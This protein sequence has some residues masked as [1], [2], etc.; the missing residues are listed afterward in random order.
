MSVSIITDFPSANAKGA[1]IQGPLEEILGTPVQTGCRAY[2]SDVAGT[3]LEMGADGRWHGGVGDFSALA[4][5]LALPTTLLALGARASVLGTQYTY[6]VDG[7][8]EAGGGLTP[9]ADYATLS[10][11][12]PTVGKIAQIP[13]LCGNG[14]FALRG[15]GTRWEVCPG[16]SIVRDAGAGSAGYAL[17]ATGTAFVSL[18]SYTIPAGLIGIGEEWDTD[19]QHRTNTWVAGTTTSSVKLAGIVASTVNGNASANTKTRNM[20][21]ITRFGNGFRCQCAGYP[22]ASNIPNNAFWSE[23]AINLDANKVIDFGIT[24]GA[25][26]D[27]SV[28]FFAGLRRIG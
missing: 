6:G 2:P 27:V 18:A 4:A 24:P 16:E 28:L 26:G 7:W 15:N 23:N 17:T 20:G 14:Y 25:I 1:I 3:Y 12:A 10:A 8:A 9:Y 13:R 22:T 11:K 21:T 19:V 5:L